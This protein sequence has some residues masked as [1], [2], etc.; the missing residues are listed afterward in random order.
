M[1]DVETDGACLPAFRFALLRASGEP[2]DLRPSRAA[3]PQ[4]FLRRDDRLKE[5]DFRVQMSAGSPC[6]IDAAI[7]IPA[8]FERAFHAGLHELRN[9]VSAAPWSMLAPPPALQ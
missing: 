1:P 8:S 3:A 9:R 5:D 6:P 2:L 7:A 4:L